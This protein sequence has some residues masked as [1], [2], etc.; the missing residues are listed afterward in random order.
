[1]FSSAVAF[2]YPAMFL[3]SH[4]FLS[5]N[6]CSVISLAK[7]LVHILAWGHAHSPK[8]APQSQQPPAPKCK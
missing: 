8:T 4:F 3:F 7:T 1:M 2:N 6:L 5:F